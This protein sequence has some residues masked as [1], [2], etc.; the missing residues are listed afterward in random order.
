[1]VSIPLESHY[2]LLKIGDGPVVGKD[3][4]VKVVLFFIR[5]RISDFLKK[6]AKMPWSKDNNQVGNNQV[7][8]GSKAQLLLLDDWMIVLR[9]F[10]ETWSNWLKEVKHDTL[11]THLDREQVRARLISMISDS[12]T[13][14]SQ[15]SQPS[16]QESHVSVELEKTLRWT[17][18]QR[19]WKAASYWTY[20]ISPSSNWFSKPPTSNSVIA[21]G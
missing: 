16:V 6:E 13:L 19:A 3:I 7:G 8:I 14:S 5:G 10:G 21:A 17:Y 15:N 12:K 1:M 11:V 9:P 20:L 18:R 4:S 2:S